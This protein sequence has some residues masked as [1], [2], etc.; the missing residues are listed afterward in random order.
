[1]YVITEKVESYLTKLPIDMKYQ[2]FNED[3]KTMSYTFLIMKYC[4]YLF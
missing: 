4:N 2:K 3:M 1:M